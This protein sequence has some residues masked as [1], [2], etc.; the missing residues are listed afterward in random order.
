MDSPAHATGL[1]FAAFALLAW[2]SLSF[3]IRAAM[4]GAPLLQATATT[5]TCNAILMIPVVWWLLPAPALR[6]SKPGTYLLLVLIAF[7]MIALSRLTYYFAIRRI[8]PS[9]SIPVAANT[10]AVTA[11]LAALFLGEPLSPRIFVGLALFAAGVTIVVRAGPSGAAGGAASRR[12]MILG[13]LAAGVTTFIWSSTGVM[14]KAAGKDMPPMAV[15][16]VA[17]WMGAP[18]AWLIAWKFEPGLSPG[19]IPAGNWRWVLCAAVC[20]TVAI[21]SYS[22]AM[23]HTL[24]VNVSSIT[25]LQPLLV[26]LLAHLFLRDA[27]NVT[28][29]LAL[30]S[31]MTVAGTLTVVL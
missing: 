8:G 24:A 29:R 16:A 26:I 11:L 30:G 21:P 27:E 10:P 17:I 28:W 12:D 2:S 23:G 22:I 4:K 3:F 15:A 19:R 7:F 31:G 18:M 6:P 1:M 13:Y 9:R 5:T 20:Q 14:M 25:S